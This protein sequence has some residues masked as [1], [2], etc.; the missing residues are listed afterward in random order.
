MRSEEFSS[1]VLRGEGLVGGDG[2]EVRD[3]FKDFG[4]GIGS[5]ALVRGGVGWGRVCGVEVYFWDG[6]ER[7]REGL[8][9][10]IEFLEGKIGRFYI[11]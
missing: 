3:G 10:Y 4:C 1:V 8:V 2:N 6:L 11:Y 9:V 5:G 7:R